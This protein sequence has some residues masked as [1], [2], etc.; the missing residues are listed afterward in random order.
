MF[1]LTR[2]QSPHLQLLHSTKFLNIGT[3][4]SMRSIAG[5]LGAAIGAFVRGYL[6][7][8]FGTYEAVGIALGIMSITAAAILLTSRDTS[9]G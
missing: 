1:G 6:L 3:M 4:T 2:L 8:M 9:R 5:N 7:I